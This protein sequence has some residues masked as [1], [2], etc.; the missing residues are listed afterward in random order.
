MLQFKDDKIWNAP[1]VLTMVRLLLVPLFVYLFLCGRVY[2]SLAVF[3]VAS[4]TDLLDGYIARRYHLV[5]NFGKLFDPLADK[6]MILAVLTVLTIREWVPVAVIIIVLVKEAI[7][8][9]GSVL[10][11]KRGIVVQSV[12]IGKIAQAVFCLA[13][14]SAFFH[15]HWVE[16]GFRLDT[17]C[18]TVAVVLTLLALGWYV[19]NT[20]I[21]VYGEKAKAS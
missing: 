16:T 6:L 18:F 15:P 10:V 7:M 5:T 2:A 1:N 20:L 9:L 4:L 19:R 8:L 14:V 12:P 13:N 3:A 17:I 11:L 21:L